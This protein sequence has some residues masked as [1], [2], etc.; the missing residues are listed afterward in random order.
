MPERVDEWDDEPAPVHKP[1][2]RP[3]VV[4]AAAV[5]PA[6]ADAPAGLPDEAPPEAEDAADRHIP[7]RQA[8]ANAPAWIWMIAIFCI[9]SICMM[10]GTVVLLIATF[11]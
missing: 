9:G 2:A 6:P 10:V 5:A 8:I 1:V 11:R 4:P 7:W 3:P